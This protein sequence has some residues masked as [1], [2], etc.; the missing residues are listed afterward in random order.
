MSI[1]FIA[2]SILPGLGRATMALRTTPKASMNIYDQQV[3]MARFVAE[4]YPNSCVALNDIG[5]VAYFASPRILDLQGLATV[6]ALRVLRAG[7]QSTDRLEQFCRDY[8]VQ[9]AIVY[10]A[11]L[12]Q[13]GG[14]PATWQL[15]GAW[16][17][18]DNVICADNTV[19]F[20]AVA[21]GEGPRL[22]DRLRQFESRLPPTVQARIG[23]AANLDN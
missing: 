6:D 19:H 23:N 11:V 12:R 15:A 7:E 13:W 20:Y 16:T 5:A 18:S 1:V 22:R 2:L 17:I 14:P 8:H 3:Q 21:P 4:F 10:P 9:I